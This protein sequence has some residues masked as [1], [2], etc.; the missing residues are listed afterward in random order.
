[1]AIPAFFTPVKIGPPLREQSFVGGALGANNPTQE[2][3]REALNVFGK[4]R[5]IAQIIS[6][7]SGRPRVLSLDKSTNVERLVRMARDMASDCEIVA[8]ELSSRFFGV[9]AYLRLNVDRGMENIRM[10]HWTTLGDIEA[11][12]SSYVD[13]LPV[14]NLLDIS[15]QRLQERIGTVTL[16]QISTHHL[17]IGVS[18]DSDANVDHASSIKVLAK[19]IPALSP[20]YV[21][22]KRARDALVEHLVNSTSLGQRIFPITGMGGCGKTQLVSYFIR[23]FRTL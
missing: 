2:I 8:N 11:H 15:L 9:N 18:L 1:M 16:G 4:D 7:G 3:L 10:N 23:E 13:D 14:T 22:M 12:T 6:L 17:F 19:A 21:V 5:R 20:F